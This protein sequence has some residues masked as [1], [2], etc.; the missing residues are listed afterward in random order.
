LWRKVT[1]SFLFRKT[2]FE[3]LLE[4]FPQIEKLYVTLHPKKKKIR[5][6]ADL[7]L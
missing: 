5:H 1:K 6:Y 4:K 2:F 3:E 7:H